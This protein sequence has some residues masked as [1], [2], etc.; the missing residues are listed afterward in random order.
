ML[1]T[2]KNDPPWCKS[3]STAPRLRRSWTWGTLDPI[4][5]GLW[6][7]N[8]KIVHI[9]RKWMQIPLVRK[10]WGAEIA[11]VREFESIDS[12]FGSIACKTIRNDLLRSQEL[13]ETATDPRWSV[14]TA[15]K[16][17][18]NVHRS[19]NKSRNGKINNQIA[20]LAG[21]S[22]KALRRLQCMEISSN[23]HG[24]QYSIRAGEMFAGFQPHLTI[25]ISVCICMCVIWCILNSIY[26]VYIYF[27]FVGCFTLYLC[28]KVGAI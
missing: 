9:E 2:P 20:G 25:K 11:L 18:S 26:S 27:I 3:Y 28:Q 22:G 15:R 23:L 8:E 10:F 4:G 24:A 12:V 14:R 13:N 5:Q 17:L 16:V 1:G 7:F 21:P 6:A 19:Q